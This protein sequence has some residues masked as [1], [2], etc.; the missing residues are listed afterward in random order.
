LQDM[1]EAAAA[2]LRARRNRIAH[3]A[4]EAA[5]IA[6]V[7]H[8]ASAREI[9]DPT[10]AEHVRQ[11]RAR[12]RTPEAHVVAKAA[13]M[14]SGCEAPFK[15]SVDAQHHEMSSLYKQYYHGQRALLAELLRLGVVPHPSGV[16]GQPSVY[17]VAT[18]TER[19]KAALRTEEMSKG[20]RGKRV[21]HAMLLMDSRFQRADA[22]MSRLLRLAEEHLAS[23]SGQCFLCADYISTDLLNRVVELVDYRSVRSLMLC[24]RELRALPCLRERLPHLSVRQCVGY[25]PHAIRP[26]ADGLKH[27]VNKKDVVKVYVDFAVRGAKLE[28]ETGPRTAAHA[29]AP[30]PDPYASRYI[31]QRQEEEC[32]MQRARHAPEEPVGPE[33]YR[34]RLATDAYFSEPIE[35]SVELVFAADKQPVPATRHMPPIEFSRLMLSPRAPVRTF[36]SSGGVPHPAHLAFKMNTLSCEHEGRQFAIKVTGRTRAAAEP[37]ESGRPVELVAYSKPFFVLANSASSEAFAARP[38]RPREDGR[39]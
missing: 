11:A 18:V 35:C 31:R 34:V 13:S 33:A 8:T 3:A 2:E 6:V 23:R 21:F 15:K 1:A 5:A 39:R 9:L 7:A 10:D 14:L 16:A 27:F 4:I 17:C 32:R 22:L 25:F 36:T 30:P 29:P 26:T 20:D 24:C 38:K 28:G 37:V 12:T 19:V